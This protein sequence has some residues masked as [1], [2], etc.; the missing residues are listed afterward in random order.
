MLFNG[1]AQI[2]RR[3]KERRRWGFNECPGFFRAVGVSAR[4]TE[5]RRWALLGRRLL[6]SLSMSMARLCR[7]IRV[8]NFTRQ[9]VRYGENSRSTTEILR[10]SKLAS[11]NAIA[12]TILSLEN[13]LWAV[14]RKKRIENSNSW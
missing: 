5:Y 4:N 10:M 7:H 9:I 2:S 13:R 1:D 14:A 6:R 12:R 8:I 3:R 11:V